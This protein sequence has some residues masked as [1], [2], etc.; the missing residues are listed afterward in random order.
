VTQFLCIVAETIAARLAPMPSGASASH[1][2]LSNALAGTLPLIFDGA[3]PFYVHLGNADETAAAVTDSTA[4]SAAPSTDSAPSSPVPGAG[5]TAGAA[6][7]DDE[8]RCVR[9]VAR[10]GRS[11]RVPPQ[12]CRP[13]L[14]YQRPITKGL[15]GG[16]WAR[17]RGGGCVSVCLSGSEA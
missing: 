14:E 17:R 15:G 3:Q 6:L 8:W 11:Q 13:R 4:A 7:A 5:A 16:G 10:S 1:G 9:A 12:T 2:R